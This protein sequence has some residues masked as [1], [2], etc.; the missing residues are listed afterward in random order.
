[1][2]PAFS[3]SEGGRPKCRHSFS[4]PLSTARIK[5]VLVNRIPT[6]V[7]FLLPT[8]FS[9]VSTAGRATMGIP[10]LGQIQLPVRGSGVEANQHEWSGAYV[11]RLPMDGLHRLL[12]RSGCL[13]LHPQFPF[14]SNQTEQHSCMAVEQI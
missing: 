2:L 7:V 13:I 9:L 14:A 12:K 3:Q 8:A 5:T 6:A 11:F 1:M 4:E 10:Q